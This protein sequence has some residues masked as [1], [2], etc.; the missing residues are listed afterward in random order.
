MSKLFE[1]LLLKRL[2][3]ITEERRL[4]L[5]H[6]FGFRNQHSTIDQV[7]RITDVIERSHEGKKICSVKFLGEAKAFDQVWHEG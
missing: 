5:D 3:I 1:K 6:Y 2:E 7:H 4:I